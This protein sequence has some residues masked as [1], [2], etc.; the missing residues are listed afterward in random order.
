MNSRG[1]ARLGLLASGLLLC[2]STAFAVDAQA[3]SAGMLADSSNVGS[4]VR[5]GGGHVQYVGCDR[6]K[7]PGCNKPGRRSSHR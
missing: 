3:N 6:P 1:I 2:A 7:K 4:V 5:G